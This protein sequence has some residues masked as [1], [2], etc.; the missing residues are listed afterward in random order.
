LALSWTLVLGPWS[1]G[2]NVR[3]WGRLHG[4]MNARWDRELERRHSCRPV[5][6]RIGLWE[7]DDPG[8]QES[9]PSE[10]GAW[11]EG[12]DARFQV[13]SSKFQ[14]PDKLQSPRR[15]FLLRRPDRRD[16]G[17]WDLDLSWSLIL[18]PWSYGHKARD[19]GGNTARANG[20]LKC[21]CRVHPF[22]RFRWR[23]SAS[24]SARSASLS[25]C[26]S[27]RHCTI[28]VSAPLKACLS[29]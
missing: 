24:S 21:E 5:I 3:H 29:A 4:M 20:P 26:D 8:R 13:P 19:L 14:V 11:Q 10:Y 18:G 22:L 25:F 2:H 6:S 15:N 23:M 27:R 7:T 28:G 1:Y 17:T 16:T 12:R 9:R